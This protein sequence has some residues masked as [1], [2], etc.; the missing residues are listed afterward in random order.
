VGQFVVGVQ[1]S[2][3]ITHESNLVGC[4]EPAGIFVR[5]MERFVELLR[6]SR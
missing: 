4:E 5:T 2:Q 6:G 1:N 3:E